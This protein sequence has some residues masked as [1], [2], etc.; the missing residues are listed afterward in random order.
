M[1][2]GEVLRRTGEGLVIRCGIAGH[3]SFVRTREIRCSQGRAHLRHI[4]IA[5]AERLGD[6]CCVVRL[7]FGFDVVRRVVVPRTVAF[8]V[9]GV[10]EAILARSDRRGDF[11]LLNERGSIA[12][13]HEGLHGRF[14]Y[15]ARTVDIDVVTGVEV[16]GTVGKRLGD[17]RRIRIERVTRR[18]VGVQR[19]RKS[20]RPRIVLVTV[21]LSTG[22]LV[23]RNGCRLDLL[24]RIDKGDVIARLSGRQ[25]RIGITIIEP[26]EAT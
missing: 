18:F 5:T 14:R 3:T 21:V 8:A 17:A 2:P 16:D 9:V 26:G 13:E 12:C 19:P 4:E 25:C 20:S 7:T 23:V 22:L 24:F 10:D 6:A 1:R 15:N 11:V